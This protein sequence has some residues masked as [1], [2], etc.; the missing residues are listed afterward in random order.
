MPVWEFKDFADITYNARRITPKHNRSVS[1]SVDDTNLYI[2]DNAFPATAG[3]TG[4]IMQC[5]G[6]GMSWVDLPFGGETGIQGTTGAFGGPPGSTGLRGP[7]GLDGAYAAMGVTGAQGLQGVTGLQGIT[8]LRG[9]TGLRGTLGPVGSQGVTGIQGSSGLQGVTGMR[10]T[11]SYTG[12]INIIVDAGGALLTP[13]IK[14]QIVIPV[15]SQVYK[16]NIFGSTGGYARFDISR[17]NYSTYPG[18]TLMHYNETGAVLNGTVKNRDTDITN[19]A[20]RSMS[21]EDIVIFNL[22]SVTG[23][24]RLSLNIGYS[25]I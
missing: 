15:T 9:L 2:N 20:N 19:W 21:A 14:G 18:A 7:T 4:Q 13:G 24:H 16:Y 23:M 1:I 25:I 22:V 5:G 17:T 6:T 11:A 8:G 3:A 10:G 12:M